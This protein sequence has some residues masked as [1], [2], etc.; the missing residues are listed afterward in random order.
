MSL[1][2]INL[3]DNSRILTRAFRTNRNTSVQM[4]TQDIPGAV[5][6]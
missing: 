2:T 5:P 6:K 3:G 1:D 4:D